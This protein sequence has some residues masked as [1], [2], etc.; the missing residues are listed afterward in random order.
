MKNMMYPEAMTEAVKE[1]MRRD[2]SVI[3]IG[4]DVR[5]AVSGFYV[6]LY[7]EFGPNRVLNMPLSENSVSG[8]GVGAA[9]VGMRPIIDVGGGPFMLL[10]YD[11]LVNQASKSRYLFGGQA[12]V[13]IIFRFDMKPRIG[14]AAHHTDRL[15]SSLLFNPGLK[16]VC[17]TTPYNVKGLWKTAIRDDNPVCIF[18]SMADYTRRMP[19][20]EEEYLIPFGQA[21]IVKEGKDVTLVTIFCRNESVSAA[22][23]LEKEGISVEVI[24]PLTLVPLDL[25]AIINSVKKT[26][27]LVLADI[28]HEGGSAANHVGIQVA[29]KGFR[30]LKAPIK[31]ICTPDVHIPFAPH[32]ERIIYPTAERIAREIKELVSGS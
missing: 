25:D 7:K 2:P 26:G 4:M 31:R 30:Y 20:P 16:V 3:I 17:P 10:T 23:A 5:L 27:R 1:E 28:A 6:G 18:D 11:Q 21:E 29:D 14:Q 12:K 24:D 32:L 8:M 15:H 9:I 19:V 22:A 13:P